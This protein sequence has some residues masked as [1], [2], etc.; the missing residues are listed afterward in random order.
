MKSIKQNTS[1]PQG[2]SDKV[3]NIVA[4][5]DCRDTNALTTPP[6]KSRQRM[7][8][9]IWKRLSENVDLEP[10]FEILQDAVGH[11]LNDIERGNNGKVSLTESDLFASNGHL[12]EAG[13][14]YVEEAFESIGDRIDWSN[15]LSGLTTVLDKEC[16]VHFLI[17]R[18]AAKK[19]EETQTPKRTG[20]IA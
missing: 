18:A 11:M 14:N 6:R 15:T 10:Y 7:Q 1:A 20:S 12:T 9:R 16:F 19:A 3:T 4:A 13:H 17:E 2:A 5:G 8:N